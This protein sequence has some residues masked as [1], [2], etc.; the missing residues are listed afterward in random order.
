M[1]ETRSGWY[2]PVYFSEGSGVGKITRRAQ[3]RAACTTA[4][5]P[6]YLALHRSGELRRRAALAV[7]DLRSCTVC[8][9]DCEVDRL[10]DASSI[11]RT[12]RRARVSS[13]FPHMGEEDC[14]RGT[15]GSGTI[16]F[17]ACNL[18]CVFCQNHD[19]SQAHEGVEVSAEQLANMML[20]LQACGCHNINF[21]TPEHVV[22]QVFEALVPAVE[23]GLR[24]PIVYN[25][26][27]YDSPRSL[28]LLDGVVD[29]YMPGFKFWSPGLSKRYLEAKD[30]PEVARSAV[31][32]MHRQVGS[33]QIGS[34]GV[35][36]RGVL[37]RHL[38]M[39]GCVDDL[40]SIA[41]FLAG[42]LSPD[43]YINIMAQY[44]PEHRADRYPEINRGLVANELDQAYTVAREEGLRRF[45]VRRPLLL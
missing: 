15:R 37:I 17:S 25:T 43:T 33:L 13:S 23:A 38:V 7:T 44:R 20:D 30:Y 36:M 11:C 16:F 14:L 32:E 5:E 18:R 42:E 31:R 34:D 24:L 2:H 3:E 26:S 40:R 1:V 35:A 29:I 41:R 22:P 9:R 6:A 19:I 39:P 28:E 10:A 4:I 21:V 12:G 27:A 45:D 8:P